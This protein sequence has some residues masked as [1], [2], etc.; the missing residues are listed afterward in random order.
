VTANGVPGVLCFVD[1][2]WAYFTTAPLAEQ[3]GDD[4]DDAPYE[5]NAG[6]PLERA[7][8]TITKVA[9]DGPLD[10]PCDGSLNSPWSVQ[11]IN[12]GAVAW[13][14]TGAWAAANTP[15]VAIMAGAT[16]EQFSAAVRAVGGRVFVARSSP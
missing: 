13:L 15:R 10:A 16:V 1:S 4:W 7:G 14:R 8:V 9:F 5:H 2:P 11:Q 3:W 12:S 6:T